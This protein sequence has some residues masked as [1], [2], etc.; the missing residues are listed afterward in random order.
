[1]ATE[2]RQRPIGHSAIDT[3]SPAASSAAVAVDRSVAVAGS[4]RR[5]LYL[6]RCRTRY[7]NWHFK[8]DMFAAAASQPLVSL[9]ALDKRE[10]LWCMLLRCCAMCGS[11]CGI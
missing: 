3:D 9:P 7:A 10:P 11:G 4:C 6:W 2:V 8:T 5:V 1:M